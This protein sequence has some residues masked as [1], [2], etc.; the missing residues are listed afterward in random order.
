[1]VDEKEK[2]ETAGTPSPTPEVKAPVSPAP[3]PL[4]PIG[5]AV[6][7]P[8]IE[9]YEGMLA[10][11]PTSRVFAALAE[12]Y[13]KAGMLDESIQLCLTGLGYHPNYLSGRVALGRAYFDK[14]MQKEAKEELEKVMEV[15][16]DN[17]VALK[18]L[19][20]I[21]HGEGN[22]EKA[23]SS[24]EKVLSIAPDNQEIADKLK[25]L[26]KKSVVAPPV[27]EPEPGEAEPPDI[28]EEE[29]TL[30]LVEDAEVIEE[31]EEVEEYEGDDVSDILSGDD[32]G[33]AALDIEG[34]AIPAADEL[35]GGFEDGSEPLEVQ[36]SP[37]GET[38]DE[39]ELVG[40][41]VFDEDEIETDEEISISA[42]E[43]TAAGEE[44]DEGFEDEMGI[45]EEAFDSDFDIGEITKEAERSV[46]FDESVI[47]E[48]GGETGEEIELGQEDVGEGED[49]KITTE[50]IADIYVKQ[51]Y[52]DRAL[53]I[54]EEI[55]TS[56][57]GREKL[58]SKIEFVK[59]K[60]VEEGVEPDKAIAGEMEFEGEVGV[61]AFSGESNAKQ[62]I[63]KLSGWLTKIR[64]YRKKAM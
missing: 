55:S 44:L 40:D 12:L 15:T 31:V 1:V 62:Q 14:G 38:F 30:D 18:V 46:D 32:V 47:F 60:M 27:T 5:G 49:V 16:P 33:E 54:Y 56:Q 21:Y 50:T 61:G 7:T 13:R 35:A 17:L 58:K 8:E 26:G 2:K 9:K 25:N 37:A 6:I 23:R 3:S 28:G 20:K 11:N 42:D 29:S 22:L 53:T 10:K 59:R 43:E 19:G 48:E 24:Y 36:T 45:L 39:L 63:E 4:P 41:E 34:E 51:G 57:P 64:R 52:Y